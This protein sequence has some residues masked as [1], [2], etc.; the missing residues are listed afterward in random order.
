MSFNQIDGDTGETLTKVELRKR[1]LRCAQN[2][3]KLGCKQNDCIGIVARNH[4][5]LTPLLYAALCVGAPI[6]PLDVAI[7]KGSCLFFFF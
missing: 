7:D 6:S 1:T 5:N 2:L 3:Q 4:Q